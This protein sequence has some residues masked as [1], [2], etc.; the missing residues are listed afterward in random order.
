MKFEATAVLGKDIRYHRSPSR[1][2][3]ILIHQEDIG[4]FVEQVNVWRRERG[5][6]S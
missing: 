1:Y 2:H 5:I 6:I 4:K 3:S